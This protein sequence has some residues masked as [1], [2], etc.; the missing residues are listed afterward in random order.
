MK[1]WILGNWKMN[2]SCQAV[3]EYVQVMS[4]QSSTQGKI[5]GLS[6]PS[7][8]VPHF[9]SHPLYQHGELS[10]M[11]GG[12]DCAREQKAGP[13]TGEVSASMLKDVGAQFVLVGH[14]ER[15][16]LGESNTDI[17]QKFQAAL[18]AN[19]I[20]VLCIGETRLHF[21]QGQGKDVVKQ[22]LLDVLHPTAPQA[23]WVIAYE[24]V[25]SIG[26]GL[27]PEPSYL[28]EMMGSIRTLLREKELPPHTFP[29]VLYGGSVQEDNIAMLQKDSEADG[30]LVGGASLN[31]ERFC[32]L[33]RLLV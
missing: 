21:E 25:W 23:T 33:I 22:Q 32:A 4:H 10:Y 27:I 29:P 18:A 9:L 7:V 20:P 14:S 30:F 13:H 15:R 26:T 31:A 16:T 28:K 11:I 19:L 2:G 24:P 3:S 6:V 1:Q 8:Y 12:Q 5:I 17:R